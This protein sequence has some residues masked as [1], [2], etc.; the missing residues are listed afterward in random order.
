[1]QNTKPPLLAPSKAEKLHE[2]LHPGNA[3]TNIIQNYSLLELTEE[4]D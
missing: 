2:K 3:N 4:S 1:M